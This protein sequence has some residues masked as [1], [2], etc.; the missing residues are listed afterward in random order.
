MELL[1]N[2]VG[3]DTAL[4][5]GRSQVRFPMVLLDFFID[6]ILPAAL[7]HW[8]RL[9]LKQEWVPG[10]YFLSGKGSRFLGLKTLPISCA[11][12]HEIWE[13]Q[14]DGTLRAC[15]GL[16]RDYL[17]LLC[18][19]RTNQMRRRLNQLASWDTS[20]SSSSSSSCP[21]RFRRVSCSLF[22][23]MKSVPPSL[24]RSA[25]VPSSLWFIL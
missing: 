6:I 21:W 19:P 5:A 8:G 15:P 20:S 16:C 9:S 7:W 1:G 10:V 4:Q 14:P 11:D 24:P 3:W 25:Y 22:L 17:T 12:S 13:P 18:T 23:E 2:A